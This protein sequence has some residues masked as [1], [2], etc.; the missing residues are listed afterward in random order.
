VTARLLYDV[1]AQ[2]DLRQIVHYIGIE[3]MR[4]DA[5]RNMAAKIHRECKRYAQSPSMGE[6]RDDLLQ[7]I[8]VFT[9]RPYVVFY[10]PLDDGIRVAR[11]IHGARDF[12]ALFAD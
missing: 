3:Q 12:P 6:R 11:I 2:D 5:A 8:R 10:H 1:E 7:G 4:P 9:V